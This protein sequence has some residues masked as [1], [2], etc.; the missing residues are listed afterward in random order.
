MPRRG[1]TLIDLAALLVMASTTGLM[2]LSPGCRLF[3]AREQARQLK[4]ATQQ[5]GIHQS[6]IVFA[7]NNRDRYPL[8]SQLDLA[9]NTI[10]VGQEADASRAT[11]LDSTRHVMA[12]CLFQGFVPLEMY[13]STDEAGRIEVFHD[14]EFFDPP[15][16][17]NPRLALWDP[18]F[19][20]TPEDSGFGVAEG[21]APGGF[22][23]AHTPLFADRLMHWRNTF[24]ATEAVLANR[25]PSYTL[26]GPAATGTWQLVADDAGARAAA[27]ADDARFD[28][29]RGPRSNTLRMFGDDS[30]WEGNVVYND[31]HTEFHERPDPDTLRFAFTGLDPAARRQND[32]IFVNE[33]DQARTPMDDQNTF[34]AGVRDRDIYL[35]SY[36]GGD[37][38][39]PRITMQGKGDARR[40]SID[41]FLD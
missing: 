11:L 15:H 23:Y 31:N 21:A 24:A 26:D 6:L 34:G 27:E 39:D 7:Q 29:P 37:A 36:A 25:G 19:R 2:M 3:Q 41:V 32:N 12:I 17:A 16:A 8:P 14:Y 1:F 35:R 13:V 18:A 10:D 5:R 28:T 22:S 33:D 38:A 30:A 9:G 20:A 40:W 4:D